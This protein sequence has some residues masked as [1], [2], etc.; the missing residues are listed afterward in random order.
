MEPSITISDSAARRILDLRRREPDYMLRVEVIGG[1]CAGFQ[2]QF[3]LETRSEEE[4]SVFEHHG[5][6][7]IIDPCSLSLLEGSTLEFVES[8][9]GSAFQIIHPRLR[10]ACGCGSSFSL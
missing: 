3:R 5:A 2:Y 9:T 10:S 1:G 8:L 4:D 7:V 6:H